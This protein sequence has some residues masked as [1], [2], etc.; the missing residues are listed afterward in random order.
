MEGAMKGHYADCPGTTDCW[1]EV[2]RLFLVLGVTFL[3]LALEIIG[4]TI[5]GSLAL[6]ADAGHVFG[7]SAAIMANLLAA[8]LIKFGA[9]KQRAHDV[10]FRFNIG[11]L[12]LVAGW[13]VFESIERFQDPHEII[14]PVMV[15]IAFV[16]GVGNYWQ[17]LILKGAAEEHKHHAH[18]AL[19]AHVM[20]DLMQSVAV[21]VG[22][23]LIWIF[24]WVLVDPLLS[25]GIAYWIA[26]RAYQL[27]FDPH[28]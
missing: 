20:G 19:S 2:K 23:I 18:H 9:Q 4:G 13:I 21:V 12:F 24:G 26:R 11:L 27:A 1:C 7:D 25:I 5:S 28:N 16:G 10:A 3:I 22:G 17:H 14:S 6:I 8:V 15:S